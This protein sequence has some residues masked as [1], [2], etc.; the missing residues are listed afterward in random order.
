MIKAEQ[1]K[2]SIITVCFNN[3]EGLKKTIESVKRQTFKDYEYIIVD[4]GSTD[5]TIELIKEN[6]SFIDH[7]VSEKDKGIYDAMNKGIRIAKGEY[8][9][10][11][12]SDDRIASVSTLEKIFKK[13]K[14][15]I[16]ILY[17]NLAVIKNGKLKKVLKLSANVTFYSFYRTKVALHH[18]ASFIKKELFEKYGYYSLDFKI[19]ADWAF[20]YE[21]V[22]V[23][24]AKIQ[25]L[26][27]IFAVFLAGGVSY[28]NDEREK[29]MALFKASMPEKTLKN[30]EEEKKRREKK[31]L[32]YFDK[33]MAKLYLLKALINQEISI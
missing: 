15:N 14:K 26:N 23:H 28:G 4:G 19:S 7:W 33:I 17:G 25:Y 3:K 5:G 18:Q 9:Y 27:R 8:C 32:I 6:E 30:A 22:I 31:Y 13:A 16:D 11:L 2:L 24:K 12:N 10:F 29:K 1:P 21:T 20:F